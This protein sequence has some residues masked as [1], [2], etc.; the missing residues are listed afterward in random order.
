MER[1][2]VL[3]LY[4]SAYLLALSMMVCTV[5]ESSLKRVMFS[6]PFLGA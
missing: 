6:A 2:E 4:W 1:E 5:I 3:V